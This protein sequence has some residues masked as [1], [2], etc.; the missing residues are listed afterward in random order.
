MDREEEFKLRVK[1]HQLDNQLKITMLALA[2]GWLPFLL[3]AG[4]LAIPLLV[5]VTQSE[6]MV[7]VISV[8]YIGLVF[9]LV[10]F[11][12]F[13]FQRRAKIN[14]ELSVTKAKLE[15]ETGLDNN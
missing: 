11:Y 13:V 14:A 9:G 8:I 6:L 12:S 4:L 10:S 7:F 1:R 3:I 2:L 15:M 5:A